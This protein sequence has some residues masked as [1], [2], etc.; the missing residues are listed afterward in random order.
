MN[1]LKDFQSVSQQQTHVLNAWFHS[2][3]STV[4]GGGRK[5]ENASLLH[6]AVA[7]R[8]VQAQS[9]NDLRFVSL[10]PFRIA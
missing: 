3:D 2:S 1:D 8:Q 7:Q 6:L 4:R 9:L 10:L 5:I